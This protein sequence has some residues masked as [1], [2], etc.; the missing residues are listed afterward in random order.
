[1]VLCGANFVFVLL[2]YGF[3]QFAQRVA[4]NPPSTRFQSFISQNA[5]FRF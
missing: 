5:P 1:M 2:R 4:G 3:D